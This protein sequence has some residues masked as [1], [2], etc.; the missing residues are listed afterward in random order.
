[1]M[2]G[3]ALPSDGDAA[4]ASS[5]VP[6]TIGQALAERRREL[7]VGQDVAADAVGISRSTFAAYERDARRVSPEFLRPLAGFLEVSLV[8]VLELY[9]VTC[10]LQARRALFGDEVPIA[11]TAPRGMRTRPTKRED[12]AIVERVYFDVT[13]AK[14]PTVALANFDEHVTTA[15]PLGHTRNASD[16]SEKKRSKK[17][18]S[19]K[20][21]KTTPKNVTRD[22]GGSILST[23]GLESASSTPSTESTAW[24]TTSKAKTKGKGKAKRAKKAK[25]A[26]EKDRKKAKKRS[27]RAKEA[28]GV[29][30]KR[31]GAKKGRHKRG[32]KSKDKK[33][34]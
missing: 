30:L 5:L 25:K 22:N 17:K 32:N 10:V 19:K 12:M 29:S 2:K 26:K 16:E 24:A 8:E 23:S 4:D 1:M 7:G 13:P 31:D 15:T 18:H 14:V 3:P 28:D 6:E 27:K 9:G 34:R 11:S 20:K 33:S 21:T